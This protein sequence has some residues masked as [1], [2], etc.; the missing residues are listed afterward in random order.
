M[1]LTPEQA[2]LRDAQLLLGRTFGLG[3]SLW[4]VAAPSGDGRS[5]PITTSDAGAVR[6]WVRKISPSRLQQALAGA[7]NANDRQG[8][9]G[10]A[11]AQ[12]IAVGELGS[13]TS[14][15]TLAAEDLTAGMTLTSQDDASYAFVVR[16]V[17]L[18]GGYVRCILDRS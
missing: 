9:I 6:L 2:A 8:G 17:T 7:G 18:D 3:G 10:V 14:P 12:W 5:G 16:G 11:Q 13:A 1:S 15:A 4:D